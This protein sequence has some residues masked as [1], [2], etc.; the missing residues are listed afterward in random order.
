MSYPN[1]SLFP[2]NT[3]I[4]IIGKSKD[5]IMEQFVKF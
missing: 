1:K 3:I 4:T 2:I 5:I